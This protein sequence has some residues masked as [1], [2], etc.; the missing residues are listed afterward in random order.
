MVSL[1]HAPDDHNNSRLSALTLSKLVTGSTR[2]HA[3]HDSDINTSSY[4]RVIVG[5]ANR[6]ENV[7]E[8]NCDRTADRSC[9]WEH[10]VQFFLEYNTAVRPGPGGGT[11]DTLLLSYKSSSLRVEIYIITY[12]GLYISCM[13]SSSTPPLTR[14]A[15][16]CWVGWQCSLPVI[17]TS[18]VHFLGRNTSR[19]HYSVIIHSLRIHGGI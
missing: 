4:R 15:V 18:L 16:R 10:V 9:T 13:Y 11:A 14:Q 2:L 19:R 8:Y 3:S 12:S 17:H 7:L 1:D 6:I 5:L